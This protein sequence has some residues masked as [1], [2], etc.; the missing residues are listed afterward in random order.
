MISCDWWNDSCEEIL[1]LFT[2]EESSRWW[3]CSLVCTWKAHITLASASQHTSAILSLRNNSRAA[4]GHTLVLMCPTIYPALPSPPLSPA[5]KCHIYV[6]L[7][8]CR[9]DDSTASLGSLFQG[10]TMLSGK[11]FFFLLNLNLSL[12]WQ[13]ESRTRFQVTWVLVPA[14]PQQLF[15]VLF[16]PSVRKP[17]VTKFFVK[18]IEMEML[19]IQKSLWFSFGTKLWILRSGVIVCMRCYSVREMGVLLH[20]GGWTPYPKAR[21][22]FLTSTLLFTIHSWLSSCAVS[23]S[24]QSPYQFTR[25]TLQAG[26]WETGLTVGRGGGHKQPLRRF[27]I[28]ALC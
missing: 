11:K 26:L 10:L 21:I 4:L 12:T 5:P 28:L 25:P 7:N 9:D 6:P 18:H 24:C 20:R 22:Q 17:K 27:T 16:S 1:P 14:L 8:T 2:G 15:C 3:E 23:A 13:S 19:C